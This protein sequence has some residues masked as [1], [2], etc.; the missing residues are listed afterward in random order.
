MTQITH[1]S[2]NAGSV[3]L[4]K[5]RA[6]DIHR[7]IANACLRLERR[8]VEVK[9]SKVAVLFDTAVKDCVTSTAR[10]CVSDWYRQL[11]WEVIVEGADVS[12]LPSESTFR[13]RVRRE[14]KQKAEMAK[15]SCAI[16]AHPMNKAP[17]SAVPA[18]RGSKSDGSVLPCFAG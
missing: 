7:R 12:Y 5:P 18:A 4:V 13:R 15:Q 9:P 3:S 17:L 8:V 2:A 11:N 1:T 14:R 16:T 6:E 10:P